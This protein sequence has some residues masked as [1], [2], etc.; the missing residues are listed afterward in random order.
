[1]A[2]FET[3][4]KQ[5]ISSVMEYDFSWNLLCYQRSINIDELSY[6]SGVFLQDRRVQGFASQEIIK[7]HHLITDHD[8]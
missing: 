5:K 2:Y 6:L 4:L 3:S 7:C 8:G 1:V